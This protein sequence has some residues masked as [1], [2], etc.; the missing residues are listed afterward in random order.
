MKKILIFLGLKI[1]EIS[2]FVL[3][4]LL[5]T[6]VGKWNPLALKTVG[7]GDTVALPETF[8]QYFAAGWVYIAFLCAIAFIIVL[9]WLWIKNNIDWTNTIINKK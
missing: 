3:V 4:M 6:L 8:W 9:G 7:E 1:A 2:A 5:I